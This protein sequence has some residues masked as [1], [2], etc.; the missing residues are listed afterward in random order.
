MVAFESNLDMFSDATRHDIERVA[1]L[2]YDDFVKEMGDR[3]LGQ[4]TGADGVGYRYVMSDFLSRVTNAILCVRYPFLVPFAYDADHWNYDDDAPFS[5]TVFDDLPFGWAVRFGLAL[6]EDLK[7]VLDSSSLPVDPEFPYT[8]DQVKEKFGTLRWYSSNV[9]NDVYELEWSIIGIYELISAYTCITC[10][11]VRDIRRSGGWISYQCTDC[12]ARKVDFNAKRDEFETWYKSERGADS[13]SNDSVIIP[14]DAY[15][16][17]R[18]LVVE[19]TSRAVQPFSAALHNFARDR[20]PFDDC[21]AW[22]RENGYH[23]VA[24]MEDILSAEA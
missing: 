22:G 2:P 24:V 5:H 8:V 18:Q 17:Y 23:F 11:S 1:G 20:D 12:L 15:S 16:R 9:P 7:S 4:L 3:G 10:G 14:Y 13:E 19:S 6:C 21:L